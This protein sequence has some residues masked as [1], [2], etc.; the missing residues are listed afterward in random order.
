MSGVI[1]EIL[2]GGAILFRHLSKSRLIARVH[3]SSELFMPR[4]SDKGESSVDRACDRDSPSARREFKAFKA[5]ATQQI[6]VSGV[7]DCGL[8]AYESPTGNLYHGHIDFNSIDEER[9]EEVALRL[10]DRASWADPPPE[11]ENPSSP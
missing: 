6:A 10:K 8:K 9:W 7:N 1:R 5:K 11:F 2:D 3:F 4:E